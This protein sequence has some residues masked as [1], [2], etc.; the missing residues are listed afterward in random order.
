MLVT[1]GRVRVGYRIGERLFGGLSGP[2]AVLH[3]VGERPG[4]GHRTCSVYVTCRRGDEWSVADATDHQHTRVV[5]G[6]ATTALDPRLGA[7]E[8]LRV[9]DGLWRKA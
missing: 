5:A 8:A 1:A 3:V 4:T 6:I 7:A 9:L 2:R